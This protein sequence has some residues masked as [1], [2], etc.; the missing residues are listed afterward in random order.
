METIAYSTP[1]RVFSLLQSPVQSPTDD[2]SITPSAPDMVPSHG[3]FLARPPR[4]R[5]SQPLSVWDGPHLCLGLL[6]LLVLSLLP[7][8]F[9]SFLLF[10]SL[11][12]TLFSVNPIRPPS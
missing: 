1:Y 11:D 5:L 12:T 9:L 7:S 4:N 2:G 6:Y 3:I 10:L 8:F